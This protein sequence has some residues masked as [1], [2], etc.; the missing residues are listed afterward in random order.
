ML[1]HPAQT[2]SGIASST[3][4]VDGELNGNIRLRKNRFLTGQI[5]I[6]GA[7]ASN[8]IWGSAQVKFMDRTSGQN[9]VSFNLATSS[10]VPYQAPYYTHP[11][12]HTDSALSIGGGAIGM[13]SAPCVKGT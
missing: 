1:H 2:G 4:R 8:G 11:S 5:V 9:N 12:T 7:A 3:I 6:N 13:R 10:S